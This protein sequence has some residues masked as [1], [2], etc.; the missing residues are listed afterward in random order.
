MT[1][2]VYVGI[3][4]LTD[5]QKRIMQYV[6]AW[7]HKEHTPVPLRNIIEEMNRQGTKKP[8]TIHA[9]GVILKKGY[10]RRSV[11]ISNK[12]SFVQLKRV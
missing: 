10:M 11:T 1:K 12:T 3:S 6:D 9:I 8:T 7:A 2:T 5:L 4:E